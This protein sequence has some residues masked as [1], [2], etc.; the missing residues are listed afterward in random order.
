MPALF[1][2]TSMRP[3]RSSVWRTNAAAWASSETSQVAARH[4]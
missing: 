3:K 4:A 1:T 2:S